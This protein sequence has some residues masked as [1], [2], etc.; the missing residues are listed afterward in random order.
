VIELDNLLES[1]VKLTNQRDQHSLE[2][3]LV[4]TL[5]ENISARDI[6]LYA[7]NNKDDVHGLKLIAS[8]DLSR[9]LSKRVEH[10]DHVLPVL[11]SD[12]D[13]L[14]CLGTQQMTI[15]VSANAPHTRIVHPM[16]GLNGVSGFLVIRGDSIIMADQKL[17]HGLL[18]IYHNFLKLLYD[19]E[20][21]KLTSL[22]NRK[23]F[24]DR[25]GSIL[26]SHRSSQRRS[27]DPEDR[28]C[29]VVL[30]IDHF[31]KI[32]DRFGHLYGDEVLLLFARI[33]EQTFRDD[34]LLF[35]YGGEEFV[36]ILKGVEPKTALQ[37][38]ERFRRTVEDFDFPQVGRVT[39]SIGA[40]EIA[41][42]D[43][44]VT[45]VSQADQAL[46]YAKENGR[47]QVQSFEQLLAEGKLT[48]GSQYSTDVEL[49]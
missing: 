42:Q 6:A 9:P 15:S 44:P 20:R 35:R 4:A 5:A 22:L 37:V 14:D 3:C 2:V 27:K 19:N 16:H 38:L 21:D 8:A 40:V 36:V 49:Y 18:R 25:L 34:D 30:D 24:N 12:K 33:M 29:L 46:Y 23:T 39:V 28:H 7:I 41:G 45:V 11:N 31:K 17:V 47:N 43:M 13:M 48:G 1:L 10:A 32:N 26:A